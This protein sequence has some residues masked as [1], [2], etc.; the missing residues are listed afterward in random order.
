M[1]MFSALFYGT[2]CTCRQREKQI[3]NLDSG[4]L[5]ALVFI[6]PRPNLLRCWVGV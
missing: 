2:P 5:E 3:S 6:H 4:N 1:C